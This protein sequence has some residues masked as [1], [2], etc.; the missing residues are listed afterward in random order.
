MQQPGSAA[1]FYFVGY[2]GGKIWLAIHSN[3]V[4]QRW[5]LLSCAAR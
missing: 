1:V 2:K 4:L 5:A 3:Q